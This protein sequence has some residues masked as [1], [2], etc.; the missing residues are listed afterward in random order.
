MGAEYSARLAELQSEVAASSSATC[1][2][3]AQLAEREHEV[4]ELEAV[5]SREVAR[6][7]V[8]LE[9][10]KGDL[11]RSEQQQEMEREA[12]EAAVLKAK[13]KLEVSEKT[14]RLQE[15]AWADARR[16]MEA[17]VEKLRGVVAAGEAAL[18]SK[19]EEVARFE[20]ELA[21]YKARSAALLQKKNAGGL[22]EEL[23]DDQT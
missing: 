17:Q 19:V 22:M 3:Q 4:A 23:I 16:G 14:R 8:A 21:A 9:A 5:S 20:G 6:L 2:L 1:A 10:C 13:K 18:A 7:N 11:T 12:G 15:A